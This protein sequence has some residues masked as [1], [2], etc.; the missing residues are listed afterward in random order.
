[1]STTIIRSIA[2]LGATGALVVGGATAANA[3]DDG[4]DIALRSEVEQLILSAV[5]DGT[6]TVEEEDEIKQAIEEHSGFEFESL[7][8]VNLLG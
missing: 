7:D 5:E 3:A 2:V 6:V 4:S 8:N 1:M